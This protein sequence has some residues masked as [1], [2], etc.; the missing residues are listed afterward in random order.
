MIPTQTG[1]LKILN[2]MAHKQRHSPERSTSFS[3]KLHYKQQVN[4]EGV[5]IHEVPTP[6]SHGSKKIRA[7][8]MA[9][10]I[11]KKQKK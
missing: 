1:V 7:E 6:V 10:H 5:I 4:R 3:L 9:K 11:S 8:D 2:K